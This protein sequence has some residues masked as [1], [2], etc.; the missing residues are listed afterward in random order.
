MIRKT[1]IDEQIIVGRF[2]KLDPQR[3]SRNEVI[4]HES[5]LCGRAIAEIGTEKSRLMD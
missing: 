5:R 3:R 2:V 1:K 4:L